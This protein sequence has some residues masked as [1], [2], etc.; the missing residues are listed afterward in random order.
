[1]C[2]EGHMGAVFVRGVTAIGESETASD[3]VSGNAGASTSAGVN[4]SM[5]GFASASTDADR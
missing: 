1:M 4:G 5:G 3:A 2:K